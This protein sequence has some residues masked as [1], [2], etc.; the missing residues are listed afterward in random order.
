[1][2]LQW[3]TRLQTLFR[4]RTD[5]DFSTAEGTAFMMGFFV[6]LSLQ[7]EYEL[8]LI[9]AGTDNSTIGKMCSNYFSNPELAVQFISL[10]V[11]ITFIVSSCFF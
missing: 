7:A 6:E 8:K 4:N 1:M 9:P 10:S 3:A 11:K 2:G 5:A